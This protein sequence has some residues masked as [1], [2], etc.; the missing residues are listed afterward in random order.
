MNSQQASASRVEKTKKERFHVTKE[1]ML[2]TFS[3]LEVEIEI[4]N[5]Q[6]FQRYRECN[7][8]LSTTKGTVSSW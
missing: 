3:E 1:D 6:N 4:C 7:V 2:Q 5:R 8:I